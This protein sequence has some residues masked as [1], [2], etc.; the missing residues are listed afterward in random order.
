MNTRWH[1]LALWLLVLCVNAQVAAQED[2][3]ALARSRIEAQRQRETAQ[4]DAQ[5]QACASRFAVT[6]CVNA[7]HSQR[8]KLLAELKRQDDRLVDQQRQQRSQEQA[9][10]LQA[11]QQERA[12][13]QADATRAAQQEAVERKATSAEK[14]AQRPPAPG[15][16]APRPA[17]P[18]TSAPVDA[19]ALQQS[20]ADYAHKQEEAQQRRARRDKHVQENKAS[21]P[22]PLPVPP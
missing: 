2:P 5:E 1:A 7:V 3:L 10:A 13:Q 12:R 11:K 14:S 20:R 16:S 22:Q 21:Q 9:A 15:A 19:A 17:R 8:R 18:K 6:D 4:F